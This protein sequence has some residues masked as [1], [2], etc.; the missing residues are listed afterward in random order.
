VYKFVEDLTSDVMFI[1]EGSDLAELLE[2]A[3]LALFEVVCQ[4]DNVEPKQSVNIRVEAYAPDELLHEWLS[5]LLTESDANELFFSK[6]EIQVREDG[7]L[8]AEGKAWGEPYSQEKSGTVVKGVTYY[9]LKVEKTE[10]GYK[11]KVA[12]DI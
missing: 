3:S 12:C 1:A 10:N 8:V 9:G 5:A 2:Q 6:F 4:R 11:A 7:K